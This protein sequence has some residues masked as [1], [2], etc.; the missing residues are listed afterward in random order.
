M[1]AEAKHLGIGRLYEL[2]K[3]VLAPGYQKEKEQG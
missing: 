3:T 1:L 2:P